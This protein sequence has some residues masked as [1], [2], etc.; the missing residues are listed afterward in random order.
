[1]EISLPPVLHF[2]QSCQQDTG[3]ADHYGA[4]HVAAHYCN[5]ESPPLPF[6]HLWQHGCIAPWVSNPAFHIYNYHAP[7]DKKLF[8]ARKDEELMLKNLGYENAK[9][10]GLPMAYV[11]ETNLKRIPRSLLIMPQHSL[12]GTEIG[13]DQLRREYIHSLVPYLSQ[14]DIVAACVTANCIQNGFFVKDFTSVGIEILAGAITSDVNAYLRIRCLMEQFESMTTNAW[15][16][17]VGYGLYFG[18]KTSLFGLPFKREDKESM[19]DTTFA[20]MSQEERKKIYEEDE[21]G[22]R[23]FLSH[24]YTEPHLGKQDYDLG[25]QLIGADNKC[26]PEELKMLFNW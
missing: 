1:M 26:S 8:V 13:S 15:G 12:I 17:H 9:A 16:S 5:I 7:Y 3:W 4:L 21:F 2:Q 23:E 14:F 20:V 6:P 10:I 22:P 11:P 24:L 19:K 18:M 25:A